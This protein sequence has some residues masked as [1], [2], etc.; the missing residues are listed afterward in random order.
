MVV[1]SSVKP[2]LGNQSLI[3]NEIKEPLTCD[4]AY[5]YYLERSIFNTI[6]QATNLVRSEWFFNLLSNQACSAANYKPWI[7]LT[8][9]RT[10]DWSWYCT[11][12]WDEAGQMGVCIWVIQG[13]PVQVGHMTPRTSLICHL[14][15]CTPNQALVVRLTTPRQL[16]TYIIN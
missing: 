4:Q 1:K 6:H 10:I 3:W 8:D 16:W 5:W 12:E 13:Q 15:G 11:D 9:S 2:S 14:G 7:D